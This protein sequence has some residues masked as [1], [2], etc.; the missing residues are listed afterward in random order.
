MEALRDYVA[1]TTEPM[2]SEENAENEER[3][4]TDQERVRVRID[5]TNLQMSYVSGFRPTMTAEEL[6]LDI[7]VNQLRSSDDKEQPNE[8]VFQASNRLV[9]NYYSAKRMAISLAQI[10]RQFEQR[11]GQIELNAVKRRQDLQK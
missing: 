9:M 11:F 1:E 6:V 7:G 8:L 2:L 4:Q 10:V 3:A 5:E